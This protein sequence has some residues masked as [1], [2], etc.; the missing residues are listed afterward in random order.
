MDSGGERCMKIKR[1]DEPFEVLR[2]ESIE[3][4]GAE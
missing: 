3:E 1:L 4:L 2:A